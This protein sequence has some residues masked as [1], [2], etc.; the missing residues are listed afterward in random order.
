[1]PVWIRMLIIGKNIIAWCR[2]QEVVFIQINGVE[3]IYISIT[4]TRWNPFNNNFSKM[5]KIK[6][7][8]FTLAAD[9]TVLGRFPALSWAAMSRKPGL[10][11]A[12]E[13]VGRWMYAS[14]K[15]RV[16]M[17]LVGEDVEL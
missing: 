10:G 16:L 8:V 11:P 3:Q 12:K 17:N 13:K 7:E 4:F 14:A 5:V 15:K 2:G 1:M 6:K 9:G